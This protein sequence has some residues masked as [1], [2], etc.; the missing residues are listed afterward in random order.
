MF[1][2]RIDPKK[3]NLKVSAYTSVYYINF[4][5]NLS[6]KIEIFSA[7]KDSVRHLW[8]KKEMGREMCVFGEK[9]NL[10][11]EGYTT[12]GLKDTH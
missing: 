5:K 1:K 11:R 9:A 3:Y 2:I 8:K 7:S 12:E 6:P 4:K 10:E